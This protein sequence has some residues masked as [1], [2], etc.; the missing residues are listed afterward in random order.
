MP[1]RL[2]WREAATGNTAAFAVCREKKSLRHVAMVAK[3]LND[4]KP[5]RHLKSGFALFQ[6]SLIFFNFISFV[7]C[8]RNFLG[9][10]RK[11]R[12]LEKE[13]FCVV[14][15]YSI[16]RARETSMFHVAVVQQRLRNVQKS[17]MHVQ[18]FYFCQSKPIALLLFAVAKTP[19]CCDPNIL[20]PW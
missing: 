12:S 9:W 1:L 11:N 4:N 7:K 3:F 5:K 2:C 19:C 20:L 14:L 18:S 8:W 17:V 13:N 6:T 15:T 16:K 10:I